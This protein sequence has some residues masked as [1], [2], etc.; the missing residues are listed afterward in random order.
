[1]VLKN[2][3]GTPFRL[4]SPNPLVKNQEWMTC[5]QLIFHNF[6]WDS[7]TIATEPLG[8]RTISEFPKPTQE[9]PK[10]I[11][12][13][14]PEEKPPQPEIEIPQQEPKLPRTELIPNAI[15]VYCLPFA[16][17]QNKSDDLYE[18][19]YLT[20]QYNDKFTFEA[21]IVE[22]SD[23][24]ISLWTT[25][26]MESKQGLVNTKNYL[27]PESIIFPARYSDGSKFHDHRWWK[28]QSVEN[29]DSGVA[30]VGVITNIHPSFGD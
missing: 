14:E 3:D 10:P 13:P 15:I 8:T 21:I 12:A 23:F 18:D 29:Q 5:E 25:E 30:I 9:Q 2:R 22:R 28:V 26:S 6:K 20:P 7:F 16:E 19:R 4:S 11:P 1:M 17:W 27:K 24:A